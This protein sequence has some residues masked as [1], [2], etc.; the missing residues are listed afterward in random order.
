MM[1][2]SNKIILGLAGCAMVAAGAGVAFGNAH[3]VNPVVALQ[4]ASQTYANTVRLY[5]GDINWAESPMI[6]NSSAQYISMVASSATGDIA[7][8]VSTNGSWVGDLYQT[9]PTVSGTTF[10]HLYFKQGDVY[11]HP[12][13]GNHVWNTDLNN[14]YISTT[15]GSIYKITYSDWHSDG[16]GNK[17]FDYSILTVGQFLHFDAGSGALPTGQAATIEADG[18]T[19]TL[20]AACTRTDGHVFNKW[21]YNG[22]N[23]DASASVTLVAGQNTVT[24]NY[25]VTAAS[26]ADWI[27]NSSRDSETCSAKYASASVLWGEMS[28]S[29]QGNFTSANYAA[30]VA[31]WNAWK[32]ANAS[33]SPAISTPSAREDSSSTLAIG[34]LAGAAVLVASAYFFARK[35]RHIA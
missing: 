14:L 31:R 7:N 9:T 29:E 28:S 4:D 23:Y 13:D 22:A 25:V 8:Y 19:A 27:M 24:A 30:A 34:A 20:P 18:T 2:K 33:S 10:L 32:A 5:F 16:D 3:F 26:F 17:W 1:K 6:G 35:K 11:W 12:Y 15:P 21:T